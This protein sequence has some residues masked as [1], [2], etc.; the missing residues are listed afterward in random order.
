MREHK[1]TFTK[2]ISKFYQCVEADV[3]DKHVRRIL[4]SFGDV[5]VDPFIFITIKVNYGDRPGC[6][7]IAVVQKTAA[8]RFGK[9]REEAA[10]FLKN[11]MY[12]DNVTGEPMTKRT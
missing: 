11:H 3:A 7:V 4:W 10:W 8:E 9:G 1:I 12:V 2:D 5:E 6:I